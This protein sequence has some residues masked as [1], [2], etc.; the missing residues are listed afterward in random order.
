MAP[1]NIERHNIRHNTLGRHDLSMLLFKTTL[2]AN[3]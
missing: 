3:S 1:N 2:T